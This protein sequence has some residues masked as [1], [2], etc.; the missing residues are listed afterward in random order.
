LVARI[1]HDSYLASR[2]MFAWLSAL[3]LG[4]TDEKRSAEPGGETVESTFATQ[5]GSL[6]AARLHPRVDRLHP[7]VQNPW[8]GSP[9]SLLSSSP[10]SHLFQTSGKLGFR[11]LASGGRC[12]SPGSS[13]RPR[14][15]EGQ[16]SVSILSSVGHPPS[17]SLA[18][19]ALFHWFA[20]SVKP[21]GFAGSL[22]RPSLSSTLSVELSGK[23]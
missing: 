17:L 22:L 12:S 18:A 9:P 5:P 19:I 8:M 16:S 11:R 20:L 13:R 7:R 3:A 10:S 1:V 14:R 4:P 2:F 23:G 15:R 21:F 6:H